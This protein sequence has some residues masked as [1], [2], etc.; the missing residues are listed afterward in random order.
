MIGIRRPA[1]QDIWSAV[2][3]GCIRL[4][5]ALADAGDPQDMVFHVREPP[6]FRGSEDRGRARQAG[7]GR[8]RDPMRDFD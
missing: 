1:F 2:R 4:N 8:D 3:A 5:R 7:G 6:D